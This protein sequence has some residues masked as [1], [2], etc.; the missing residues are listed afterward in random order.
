MKA[1]IFYSSLGYVLKALWKLLLL[2][3]YT[4][5]KTGETLFGFI[6]RLAEKGL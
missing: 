3:L 1:N 4:I 5:G 6:G 2:T